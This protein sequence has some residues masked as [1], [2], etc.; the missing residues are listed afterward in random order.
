[1]G[2]KIALDMS[3]DLSTKKDFKVIEKAFKY[4]LEDGWFNRNRTAGWEIRNNRIHCE[5]TYIKLYLDKK[6]QKVCRADVKLS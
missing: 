2:L 1:M 5:R 4:Q 6:Q 3:R